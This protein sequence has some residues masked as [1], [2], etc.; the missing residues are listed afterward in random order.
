MLDAP[1]YHAVSEKLKCDCEM[2]LDS[3]GV[4]N[5]S[6]GHHDCTDSADKEVIGKD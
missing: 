1:Y 4:A 2:C 6:R 5:Y 3:Y